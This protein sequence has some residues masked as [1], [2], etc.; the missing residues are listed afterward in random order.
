MS[1]PQ[2]PNLLGLG[3]A[4]AAAATVTAAGIAA[5]RLVQH[6]RV[7]AALE[8]G[9]DYSCTPTREFD[10]VADDGVLLHVEIDEPDE[11][12]KVLGPDGMPVT[13]VLTHGYT[14]RLACWVFQRRALLAAGYRLVL[15]D[16]RAH[17]KSGRGDPPSYTLDQ[18]GRDL[19]AVIDTAA[20]TGALVLVGHSMGGMTMIA[21]A[22]EFPSLVRERVIAAA[23]VA[24][25]PGG[26]PVALGGLRGVVAKLL[27]HRV[28]S[29][30]LGRL[31]QRRGLVDAILEQGREIE[32]VFVD[33]FSFG[34]PVPTSVVRL[35]ADMIF[36]TP[37][38]VMSD[39]VTAFDGF[40]KRQALAAF[41]DAEALVFNGRKDILTPP[42][43]SDLIV[44]GIPGAEHVVVDDAGH[45]IMLEHP[46]LLN[47][48]LLD[49]IARAL[50][51]CADAA[52]G[53]DG[54]GGSAGSGGTRKPR[55]RRVLT[56]L[57]HRRE[58]EVAARRAKRATA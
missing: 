24:T 51:S 31:S 10:V 20:P 45:V 4:A 58:I 50:K 46:H 11:E 26:L 13:V 53:G 40:D 32:A 37:L 33:R 5:E 6:R 27:I 36:A 35:L 47:E 44:A 18:L 28:G 29:P 23:F 17:G 21:L 7:E 30:V 19:K 55:V 54:S 12:T 15:W 25:S 3:L 57:R 2:S 38:D 16:Q 22:D 8:T 34:S 43:H 56:D 52:A 9:D 41:V 14:H 42:A 1:K 49:L 48:E 39:F